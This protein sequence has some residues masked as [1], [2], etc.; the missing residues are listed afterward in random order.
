MQDFFS[1]GNIAHNGKNEEN[2]VLK[3]RKHQVLVKIE[4]DGSEIG[5]DPPGPVFELFLVH[6][7]H[8]GEGGA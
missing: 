2:E 6:Q 3:T 1:P 8:A 7:P 5:D 4:R